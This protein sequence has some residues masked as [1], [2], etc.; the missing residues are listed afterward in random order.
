MTATS[1]RVI[2][3]ADVAALAVRLMLNTALTRAT[4]DIDG[5]KQFVG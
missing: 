1:G 5:G 2:G 4:Y 3:P